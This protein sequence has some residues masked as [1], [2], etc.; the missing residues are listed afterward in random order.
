[1]NPVRATLARTAPL[2]STSFGAK[3]TVSDAF[4]LADEASIAWIVH[5]SSGAILD[6]GTT[7]Q[8]VTRNQTLALIARDGGCTPPRSHR[9]SGWRIV[10]KVG[11]PWYIPPRWMDSVQRPRRNVRQ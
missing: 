4:K 1:M 6:Y 7:R 3:L 10:M 9:Q 8:L 11:V 2:A 5:N